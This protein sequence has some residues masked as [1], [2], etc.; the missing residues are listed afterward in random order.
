M[1]GA[2]SGSL[3]RNRTRPADKGLRVIGGRSSDAESLASVE[4][5]DSYDAQW[6]ALANMSRRRARCA[7]ACVEGLVYVVGGYRD[8]SVASA[9]CYDPSTGHRRG[10]PDM[11]VV[12]AIFCAAACVDGLLT[13]T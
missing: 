6:G 7:G 9:E 10:V 5:Y 11:S 13:M 8:G 12:R 4:C 3:L 1:D 2:D